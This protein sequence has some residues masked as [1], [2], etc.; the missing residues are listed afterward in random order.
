[1]MTPLL[2]GMAV[3]A[4]RGC[5]ENAFWVLTVAQHEEGPAP[6]IRTSTQNA[7]Q[8]PEHASLKT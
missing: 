6:R 7:H 8:H 3:N 2:A 1:M 5:T 4:P